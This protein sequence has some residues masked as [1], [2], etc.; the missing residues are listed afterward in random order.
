MKNASFFRRLVV[1]FVLGAATAAFAQTAS[2]KADSTA[3]AAG[4]G[5]VALKASVSYDGQPAALGWEIALPTDWTLVSVSGANVPEIAPVAGATGTLEFAYTSAPAGK[6]EFTV[7]VRYPV[8]ST[9]A[10]AV[11]TVL[12]R[13][14]GKLATLTP[15]P[16]EFGK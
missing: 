6:A 13:A 8:G 1:T 9:T 16:I 7:V 10:K 14:N 5:S 2:L 12:V 4:G 3:L 11:P 15:A